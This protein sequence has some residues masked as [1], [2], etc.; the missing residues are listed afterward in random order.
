MAVSI[1]WPPPRLKG[2]TKEQYRQRLDGYERRSPPPS[3]AITLYKPAMPYRSDERISVS[4]FTLGVIKDRLEEIDRI[5]KDGIMGAEDAGAMDKFIAIR[6]VVAK[7][8]RMGLMTFGVWLMIELFAW[9]P[10][11]SFDPSM[12]EIIEQTATVYQGT[13]EAV[14]DI[15]TWAQRRLPWPLLK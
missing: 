10:Y 12:A 8:S 9:P 5:A 11:G 3:K 6:D 2:E 7:L 13:E 1:S 15:L 14:T 4:R